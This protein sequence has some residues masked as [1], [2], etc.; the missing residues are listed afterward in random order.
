MKIKTIIIA[1]L[2]LLIINK[3][4]SQHLT[5]ND[6]LTLQSSNV[7][8]SEEILS[9][10]GFEFSDSKYDEISKETTLN[11]KYKNM[12]NEYFSKTCSNLFASKCTEIFYVPNNELSFNT[13]KNN[14]KAGFNKFFYSDTNNKGVLSHHYLIAAFKSVDMT[15]SREVVLY[16]FPTSITKTKL[17]AIGIKEVKFTEI[18]K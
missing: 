5:Y 18:E 2:L 15:Y 9:K 11:W 17:F 7:E 6:L 8:K 14:M 1:V 4:I 3:G 10:K 13:I 16:T 12:D